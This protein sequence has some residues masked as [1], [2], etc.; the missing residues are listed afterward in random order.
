MVA[1]NLAMAAAEVAAALAGGSVSLFADSVDFLED[2]SINLLVLASLGWGRQARGRLG[3][4]L[5]AVLL[6]PTLATLAMAWHRFRSDTA[7]EPLVIGAVGLVALAVNTG[8][9]LLLSRH[10]AARGSLTRAA[11]LSARNDTLAN[12]AIVAAG[13]VTLFWRSP[14]PDLAVGLGIG[15]LNAGAAWEVWEAARGERRAE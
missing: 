2:A 8:C 10:R 4:V 3:A 11:F 12:V 15:V 1:L 14:W 7:P 5:A 6:A 9:A 13:A